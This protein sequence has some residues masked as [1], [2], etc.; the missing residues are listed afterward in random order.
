MANAIVGLRVATTLGPPQSLASNRQPG[1]N[2]GVV[3]KVWAYCSN[4]LPRVRFPVRFAAQAGRANHI[5]LI[6]DLLDAGE[7]A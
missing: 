7:I 6:V 4:G 3:N 5:N 1:R 2:A